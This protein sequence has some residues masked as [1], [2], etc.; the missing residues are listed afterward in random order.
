M[1]IDVSVAGCC[2]HPV[3]WTPHQISQK[4]HGKF[5]HSP[6]DTQPNKPNR[7]RNLLDIGNNTFYPSPQILQCMVGPEQGGT[8][9]CCLHLHLSVHPVPVGTITLLHLV[10]SS[11][12]LTYTIIA[13][14]NLYNHR[15]MIIFKGPG[16]RN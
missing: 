14:N 9:P 7:R 5:L 6:D 4:C 1:F 2:I 8:F 10:T 15:C 11:Q 12:E 16:C 3:I 13:T